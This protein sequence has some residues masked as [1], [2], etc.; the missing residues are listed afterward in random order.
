M[1]RLFGTHSAM[2]TSA[3]AT[4]GR[5]TRNTEDHPKCSTVNP[6]NTGPSALPAPANAA[7]VAIAFGRSPGGNTDVT[8]DS[9]A[10]ITNAAPAPMAARQ[11]M[12]I[13]GPVANDAASAATPNTPSPAITVGLRP[14]RSPIAPARSSSPAKRSP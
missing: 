8:I 10:G 7:Q 2:S 6:P 3:T 1:S 5:F 13:V 14:K 9:V 12:S 4:I 11:A